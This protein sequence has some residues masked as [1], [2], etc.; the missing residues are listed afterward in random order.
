MKVK[1]K[2]LKSLSVKELNKVAGGSEGGAEPP[3]LANSQ[4]GGKEPPQ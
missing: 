2:L 1:K 3:Q 4:P